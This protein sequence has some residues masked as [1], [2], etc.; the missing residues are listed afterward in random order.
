MTVNET[1]SNPPVPLTLEERGA[2]EE[3]ADHAQYPREGWQVF[4][5]TGSTEDNYA[6]VK[7]GPMHATREAADAFGQASGLKAWT[8]YHVRRCVT[9]DYR[10]WYQEGSS[11]VT[12]SW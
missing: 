4:D 2:R 9:W 5:E 11:P 6:E 8:V 1:D 12:T 10:V 7:A 3:W